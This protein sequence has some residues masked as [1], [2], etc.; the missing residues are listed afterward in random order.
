MNSSAG[1]YRDSLLIVDDDYATRLL[2]KVILRGTGI[3]VIEAGTG[4]E[5]I[6]L[7]RRHR[8]EIFLVLLDIILPVY[9]G[10]TI[11]EEFRKVC[12]QIPVV[13]ISGILPME[14][15]ERWPEAGLPG[16]IS[17]PFNV[18]EMK[19]IIGT[20]HNAGQNIQ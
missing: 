12:P 18:G 1:K 14:L 10:W 2:I 15:R 8:E 20:Y 11:L 19:E 6:E 17:K 4:A 9:D 7:F 3:T 16:F 5:A 13:V